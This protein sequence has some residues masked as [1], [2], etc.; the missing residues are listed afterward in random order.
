MLFYH[1]HHLRRVPWVRLPRQQ[2]AMQT[3][4]LAHWAFFLFPSF[5]SG[6]S[7][8][9]SAVP[10]LSPEGRLSHWRHPLPL[11][12]SVPSR[13][14]NF[15]N[16]AFPLSLYL[17]F[18]RSAHRPIG[19]RSFVRSLS[20]A[21]GLASLK[22]RNTNWTRSATELLLL[23]LPISRPRLGCCSDNLSPMRGLRGRGRAM[24]PKVRSGGP[25][26]SSFSGRGALTGI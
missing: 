9:M 18:V 6:K 26:S 5:V 19:G 1:H 16:Q 15:P 12:L 3:H 25:S 23:S 10:V 7:Y 17:S 24:G 4:T 2:P 13:R 8:N 11:P 21:F 20:L 22:V 14:E